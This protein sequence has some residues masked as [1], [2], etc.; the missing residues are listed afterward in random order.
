MEPSISYT[1]PNPAPQ[2][3]EEQNHKIK[4]RLFNSHHFR[5]WGFANWL[6]VR[7]PSGSQRGYERDDKIR[8]LPYNAA[9]LFHS[10]NPNGGTFLPWV[11]LGAG[12]VQ[13][14]PKMA[15]K[16]SVLSNET[17]IQR[18]QRSH[19]QV[20]NEG[21]HKKHNRPDSPASLKED[22]DHNYQLE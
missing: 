6:L 13:V 21:S 19:L 2:P 4:R 12:I 14:Y 20:Q 17:R 10:R 11:L 9:V 7:V 16:I 8:D 3:E 1:L 22:E 18:G 5:D 15:S